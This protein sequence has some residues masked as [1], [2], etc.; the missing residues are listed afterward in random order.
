VI[1][2]GAKRH[3]SLVHYRGIKFFY[4]CQRVVDIDRVDRGIAEIGTVAEMERL[5]SGRVVNVARHCRQVANLAWTM[6][7]TGAIGG[8]AIPGDTDQANVDFV[9]IAWVNIGQAHESCDTGEAR[10]VVAGNRF[11]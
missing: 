10:Q 3:D 4:A 6:A 9:G 8:T 1:T 11:V 2:A 7:S 5:D